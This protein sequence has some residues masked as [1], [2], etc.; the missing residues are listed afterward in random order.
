M[1]KVKEIYSGPLRCIKASEYDG[2]DRFVAQSPQGTLFHKSY[3]LK[4]SGQ[5]FRIY[6]YFKGEELF[7]GLPLVCGAPRLGIR[8]ASHPFLTPY[9]GIIFRPSEAKYVTR[10]SDEKEMSRAIAARIKED[11]HFIQFSFTPVSTDLQPFIWEGFSSSVRYTYL[12][13]LDDLENVWKNMDAKRRNDITRAEKDGIYV[14]ASDNFEQTFTLVEKTFERQEKK[15]IFKL[16]ASKYN[17]VLSQKGQCNSFLARNKE[18]K[19]IAVVYIV[20]DEKRSYYLLGGYDPEESHHGASAIA[21]W[22][23]IKFTKEKLGLNGFD[24]EGSMIENVERFFRGFG[25]QQIP[26]FCVSSDRR[27][28]FTK[29]VMG[30]R[31]FAGKLA[32]KLGLR[33]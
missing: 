5:E 21:M 24:F 20:W 4:A 29:A 23:A 17:E 6:G 9:L 3:W 16:T 22:E 30:V 8:Y 32:R 14:E 25:G 26:Y 33:R 10:I 28:C 19:A 1:Q 15:A 31:P 11:F 12:L 27:N 18:G 2:W 7:A 13:E